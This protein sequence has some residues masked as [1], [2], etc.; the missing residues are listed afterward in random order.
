MSLSVARNF[1]PVSMAATRH[2]LAVAMPGF[3]PQSRT[4]VGEN[5]DS[6]VRHDFVGLG[7]KSANADIPSWSETLP[8]SGIANRASWFAAVAWVSRPNELS[9]I[10]PIAGYLP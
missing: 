9:P 1:L 5:R 3:D 4:T 2:R 8:E 10:Q 6:L 7:S